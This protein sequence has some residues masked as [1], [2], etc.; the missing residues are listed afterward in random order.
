MWAKVTTDLMCIGITKN[1][2]GMKPSG[3]DI[4]LDQ[5]Q[6]YR[7]QFLLLNSG[8]PFYWFVIMTGYMRNCVM[9]KVGKGLHSMLYLGMPF[10]LELYPGGE[11]IMKLSNMRESVMLAFCLHLDT[12]QLLLLQQ[13]MVLAQW[14][15][16]LIN[17][18]KLQVLFLDSLSIFHASLI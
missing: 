4:E 12:R 14:R 15:Y 18:L 9:L 8:L 10:I 13:F 6:A 16:L 3:F 17:T 7:S 5:F 11:Y 1:F 2:E